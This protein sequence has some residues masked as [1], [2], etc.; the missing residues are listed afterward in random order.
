MYNQ[1]M[2]STSSHAPSIVQRLSHPHGVNALIYRDGL[3][4]ACR[5]RHS[6]LWSYPGGKVGEGES[7]LEALL[8]ELKEETGLVASPSRC[9]F[10]YEG[11]C[12]SVDLKD[13]TYWVYSYL[14]DIDP[15]AE[16]RQ[17]PGEP[18][19][20]WMTPKDFLESTAFPE[21]NAQTLKRA[22]IKI[23]G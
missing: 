14:C 4:L 16:P 8:R 20:L 13:R 3:I 21:F 11:L 5:R 1:P 7:P 22:G 19:I 17:M 12:E 2:P 9:M 6:E 10:F 18:P 23:K 15:E